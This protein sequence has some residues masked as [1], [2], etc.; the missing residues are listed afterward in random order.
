MDL[1]CYHNTKY[2]R[3]DFIKG[4]IEG[5][6]I[7]KLAVPKM[8]PNMMMPKSVLEANGCFFNSNEV[9]SL[10]MELLSSSIL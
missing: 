2:F 1:H 3:T 7:E 8:E 10:L 5:N 9:V 4:H 6:T